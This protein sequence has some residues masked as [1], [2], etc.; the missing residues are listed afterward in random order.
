MLRGPHRVGPSV[1]HERNGW[2][3]CGVGCL[4][5]VLLPEGVVRSPAQFVGPLVGDA[6]KGRVDGSR[7]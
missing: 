5:G 7:G 4:V 2:T 6:H 1:V 3:E